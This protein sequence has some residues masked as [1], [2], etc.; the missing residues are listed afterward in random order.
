MIIT[1]GYSPIGHGTLGVRIN[2][3][4]KYFFCLVIFKGVEE[5]NGQIEIGLHFVL[6][7]HFKINFSELLIGRTTEHQIAALQIH[8]GDVLR[9]IGFFWF[10]AAGKENDSC[11]QTQPKLEFFHVAHIEFRNNNYNKSNFEGS[12]FMLA[13]NRFLW[14]SSPTRSKNKMNR[15]YSLPFDFILFPFPFLRRLNFIP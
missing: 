14:I 13:I 8:R 1:H 5:R 12:K 9:Y 15:V 10:A 11:G 7:G 2:N 3:F 6:A 4:C